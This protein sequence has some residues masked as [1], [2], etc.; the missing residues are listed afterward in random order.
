MQIRAAA[1]TNRKL[2]HIFDNIRAAGPV[3]HLAR[4]RPSGSILDQWEET[5][6]TGTAGMTAVP[7]AAKFGSSTWY[8]Y[9]AVLNK[10]SIASEGT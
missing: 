1:P 6:H 8:K 4:T 7:L 3:I 2:P 5:V 9:S 10:I